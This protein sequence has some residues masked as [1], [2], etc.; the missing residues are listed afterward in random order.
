MLPRAFSAQELQNYADLSE[1]RVRSAPFSF[2]AAVLNSFALALDESRMRVERESGVFSTARCPLRLDNRGVW[3]QLYF[4]EMFEIDPGRG[5]RVSG[6]WNGQWVDLS[7]FDGSPVLPSR[8][9]PEPDPKPWQPAWSS[10]GSVRWPDGEQP[11]PFLPVV[12]SDPGNL[13]SVFIEAEL[14]PWSPWNGRSAEELQALRS[15]FGRGLLRCRSIVRASAVSSV[16]ATVHACSGSMQRVPDWEVSWTGPMD[17][18]LSLPLFWSVRGGLIAGEVFRN[19]GGRW[20]TVFSERLPGADA[21]AVAP[22][23]RTPHL[24]AASGDALFWCDR[25]RPMPSTVR[26]SAPAAACPMMLEVEPHPDEPEVPEWVR[27]RVSGPSGFRWRMCAV[28][29][30]GKRYLLDPR[31]SGVL[32]PAPYDLLSAWKRSNPEPEYRFFLPSD[33]DYL[34]QVECQTPEGLSTDSLAWRRGLLHVYRSYS[35]EGQVSGIAGIWFDANERLWIWT[36]AHA[37]RMR[38]EYDLYA[39]APDGRSAYFSLPYEK[40]RVERG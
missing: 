3:W 20:E 26:L 19:E 30:D 29:P 27:I 34:F 10:S 33:G 5:D 21:V 4:R 18:G 37:I 1:S 32:D 6:L 17:R 13:S 25:R 22:E 14:D 35:L 23:P 31:P 15:G 36:G 7:V 40:I 9:Y 28:F 11:F 39:V 38:E 2:T 12:E 24:V 16:P 8:I